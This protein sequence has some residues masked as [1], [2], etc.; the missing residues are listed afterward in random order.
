M[1]LRQLREARGLTGDQAGSSLDRSASWISRLETGRMG[2]RA[3]DVRDLLDLYEVHDEDE[4]REFE[5]LTE[6]GRKRGWWSSYN[7]FVPSPYSNYIGLE[8]DAA[9]IKNY[10]SIVIPGL[11]QTEEYARALF[12]TSFFNYDERGIENRV[13]VRMG[14]R[15]V[16]TRESPLRLRAIVDEAVINHVIGSRDIMARQ[17]AQL[18][19]AARQPHIDVLVVTHGRSMPVLGMGSFIILHFAEP[20]FPVAYL[21]NANGGSFEEGDSVGLYETLFDRLRQA[22]LDNAHSIDLIRQAS[23]KFRDSKAE[24]SP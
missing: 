23:D 16:L 13:K 21:E 3:R 22:A 8:T 5:A 17:L 14:R 12:A 24:T 11:L 2:I 20:D 18:A 1:L 15:A 10:E 6:G 4:R 7:E 19:E 9:T